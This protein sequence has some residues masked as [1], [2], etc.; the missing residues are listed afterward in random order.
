MG[1]KPSAARLASD[2][3]P[4]VPRDR[5]GGQARSRRWRNGLLVAVLLAASVGSLIA[6][7]WSWRGNSLPGHQAIDDAIA[8]APAEA[9][10]WMRQGCDLVE[11]LLADFPD[12]ADAMEVAAQL[13]IRFGSSEESLHWLQR[14]IDLDPRFG[15]AYQ[16]L[17][18]LS[19]Q[20]GN[21]ERAA[22]YFQ[23]AMELEP[24]SLDV[25]VEY[26]EALKTLGRWDA[27]ANV[28][29]KTL[30]VDSRCVP[31]LVLLGEV[32]AQRKEYE[33]ARKTLEGALQIDPD[34]ANACYVLA[35]AYGQLGQT[36][37]SKRCL[38][39][40]RTLRAKHD[41]VYRDSLKV[42]DGAGQVKRHLAEI[43]VSASRVYLF[44]NDSATAEE[45]LRRA[46]KIDPA[47][48]ES[49]QA[50]AR[51]FERQ[52]RTEEALATW[53]ELLRQ[54]P[55]NVAGHVAFGSL[56]A[57]LGRFEDAQEAFQQAVALVPRRA[58]PHAAL[59][60]VYLQRGQNLGEAKVLALRAVDLE[61]NASNYFL[62]ST[63]CQRSG[64]LAGARTAIRHT[65]ALDP[66]N[67]EYRRV[68]EL[69]EGR[70]G[71]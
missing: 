3:S 26:A 21:H 37:Q 41:Q 29:G 55:S 38:E 22:E 12:S 57:Q 4:D 7:L 64:D 45:L 24:E 11:Q 34:C 6:T 33:Q 27:A 18:Q 58:E 51:L 56:C 15:P 49:C 59:A 28:L 31:A 36:E 43:C 53:R 48:V 10:V 54:F 35:K 8:Q 17:A 70:P 1:K 20:K 63:V 71:P 65:T 61:P 46:S 39:R 66:L 25:L 47:F 52:G 69:L 67:A 16:A 14:A 60:A 5:G 19:V 23:R 32:Q 30:E 2:T 42:A 9:A 44:H 62:L 13:N 40:F 50:L 68:K